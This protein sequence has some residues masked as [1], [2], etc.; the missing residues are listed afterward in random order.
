M[1]KLGVPIGVVAV[2]A[3]VPAQGTP[4]RDGKRRDRNAVTRRVLY[5]A[6][7]RANKALGKREQATIPDGKDGQPRVT[8]HSLR[9]TFASLA[10]EGRRGP[11]MDGPDDRA[12]RRPLHD[13]RLHRRSEPAR[14]PRRAHRIAHPRGFIG[15]YCPIKWPR[16]PKRCR[17]GIR[18]FRSTTAKLVP[19]G[20]LAQLGE[21]LP[22]KQE[23]ACSSQAP[24]TIALRGFC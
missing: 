2:F 7:E 5:P 20:R 11:G 6:I 13:E 9:R 21:R 17:P 16:Q 8:F 15:Q 24:P 3:L 10:A 22:Y 12:H 19:R 4:G 1:K 23:V 18:G 14:E